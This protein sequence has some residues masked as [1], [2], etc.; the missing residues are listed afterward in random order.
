LI[1]SM[2]GAVGQQRGQFT[3]ADVK[4]SLGDQG[5]SLRNVNPAVLSTTM[6]RLE[7]LGE[8]KI[9]KRGKGRRASVY[10]KG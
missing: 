7:T 2:R 1:D 6:K 3:I 10:K 9:V 5:V 8:I 4:T